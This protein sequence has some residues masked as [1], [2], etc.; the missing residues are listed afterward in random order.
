MKFSQPIRFFAFVAALSGA[1]VLLCANATAQNRPHRGGSEHAPAPIERRPP[2]APSETHPSQP[3]AN[4]APPAPIERRAPTQAPQNGEHLAGWLDH[5]S[6]LTP[7]QQQQALEREPGFHD[8]PPQTQQRYRD[9]IT[10]L[11]NMPP[12]QRSRLLARNEFMEHLTPDQRGQVR[13][14]MQELATLPP[15]SHRAVMRTFRVVRGMPPPQR[16]AYLNSPDIRSQF[17]PQER[18]TLQHLMAVE[19][20]LPP[21]APNEPNPNF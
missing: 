6:N 12:D 17:T 9:Q 20:Y 16:L 3:A 14:A 7:A 19:P 2:P 8:L 13:G 5:H 18:D 10:R 21:S 4:S 1:A 11:N 15:A